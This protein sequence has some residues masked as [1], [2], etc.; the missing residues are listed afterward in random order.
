MSETADIPGNEDDGE[1]FTWRVTLADGKA[2]VEA[3]VGLSGLPSDLIIH[4]IGRGLIKVGTNLLGSSVVDD[5][6][7]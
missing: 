5:E 4:A 1:D 7:Y 3:G 6:D 2:N